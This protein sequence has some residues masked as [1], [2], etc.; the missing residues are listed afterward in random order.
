M[1]NVYEID[2]IKIT[3]TRFAE[4]DLANCGKGGWRFV[5]TEDGA[6]IGPQ[7]KTK[8]EAL[9]DLPRYAAEYGCNV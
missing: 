3:R 2:G 1:A 7:Y 6:V 4:L 5:A 9:C 8:I